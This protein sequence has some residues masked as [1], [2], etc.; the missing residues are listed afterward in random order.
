[1][2]HNTSTH[3]IWAKSANHSATGQPIT[4]EEHIRDVLQQAHAILTYLEAALLNNS[5]FGAGSGNLTPQQKLQLLK[6]A[7]IL[8]ALLH[9]MGK[10]LPAFQRLRLKNRGFSAPS[11]DPL[12]WQTT[13]IPH[14]LLSLFPVNIGVL[15]GMF[16]T[17]VQSNNSTAVGTPAQ[18]PATQ[19]KPGQN[20][21]SIAGDML[22]AVL[23]AIAYHHWHA[24][25]AERY[26]FGE[27]LQE[28]ARQ[29]QKDA[30]FRQWVHQVIIQL[31]TN[32]NSAL[33]GLSLPGNSPPKCL[34]TQNLNPVVRAL[35]AGQ[36]LANLYQWVPVPYTNYLLPERVQEGD[37]R[38]QFRI[39]VLGSLMR[40]D[41]AASATEETGEQVHAEKA[42]LQQ[43]RQAIVPQ[44]VEQFLS[45][46]RN[47]PP[48]KMWQ[49][50]LLDKIRQD[51]PDLAVV[52]APTGAG[53]TE[54][55]LLWGVDGE[56]KC[57]FTL[58]LRTAVNAIFDRARRIFEGTTSGEPQWVSL[59]H[60]DADLYLLEKATV[61]EGEIPRLLDTARELAHPVIIATGD[62]VFP[63]VLKFPGYEK[64]YSVFMTS[65][66]V[67]DE[68][69][70]Y[71]PVAMGIIVGFI[72]DMLRFGAKVLLMTATLPPQVKEELENLKKQRFKV[73]F[74]DLY[75]TRVP[76]GLVR[77]HIEL[78]DDSID[79]QIN[80]IIQ[81]A[82][83]GQ[84]VLVICNTVRKAVEIYEEISQK[85]RGQGLSTTCIHLLHSRLT[86]QGRRDKETMLEEVFATYGTSQKQQNGCILVATQ[87]VEASLDIDADVL[88][89]ELA[90]IDAL[91]Q[92]MGRVWRRLHPFEN[93]SNKSYSDKETNV[94]VCTRGDSNSNTKEK[95]PSG[96]DGKV[97]EKE[98]V[99]ATLKALEQH[100]SGKSGPLYEKDKQKLVEDTFLD[101]TLQNSRYIQYFHEALEVVRAGY[102]SDKRSDA[103]RFFRR[104][105]T[106][107][108]TYEE[109]LNR[110]KKAIIN[111]VFANGVIRTGFVRFKRYVLSQ[112]AVQ[113]YKPRKV[114]VAPLYNK[115]LE[116]NIED[117][118]KN[119]L[120]SDDKV[121][122]ALSRLE[123]WCQ[124]IYV[125]PRQ[126]YEREEEN[127]QAAEQGTNALII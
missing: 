100:L 79:S 10:V 52:I 45:R 40:A 14:Q 113:D 31:L 110:I 82:Q 43:V 99:L 53:K 44:K 12:Y 120:K 71:D 90:P 75:Q 123:R 4:L 21:N 107:W 36:R 81:H 91:L 114:Q 70:A 35:A 72:E 29:W 76:S 124:N 16:R 37:Q 109:D 6:T 24:E 98:L 47:I 117:D 56:S 49:V 121:R 55:A 30:Q 118:L 74:Y 111:E 84:K 51:N 96:C 20:N 25:Q 101:S 116:H 59:L 17:L 34:I 61:E 13:L 103:E 105:H 48:D 60:S 86:M 41:H 54:L 77:H 87:V 115:L 78:I 64:Y 32:L 80:N 57:V 33:A 9:D 19:Q 104:I 3:N 112:Y 27:Q 67:V 127:L 50:K 68:V 28:P 94:Y 126:D 65:R 119:R 85:A 22:S 42:H 5:I 8:S 95:L 92:R 73:Q 1:M 46:H 62:Q 23:S 11:S 125:V 66:V 7:V 88:Y 38:K 69:Q 39:L 2:T 63:A 97:Y 106:V 89:T 58:P 26:I 102:Q 122:K 93:K 108:L 15:L 83:K 18:T